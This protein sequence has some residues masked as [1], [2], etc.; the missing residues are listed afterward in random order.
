MLLNNRLH[1]ISLQLLQFFIIEITC[2]LFHRRVMFAV[3]ALFK[4]FVSGYGSLIKLLFDYIN[5]SFVT[6]PIISKIKCLSHV[7]LFAGNLEVW[8]TNG[9]CKDH[10]RLL[11]EFNLRL[12]LIMTIKVHRII[13]RG[14]T[15][16]IL[17]LIIKVW[18]ILIIFYVAK[19]HINALI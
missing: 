1:Q 16:G 5:Y 18:V 4:G 11:I 13:C 2:L 8:V 10:F 14:R 7:Y 19:L 3:D 9:L 15:W 17:S 6:P 12:L